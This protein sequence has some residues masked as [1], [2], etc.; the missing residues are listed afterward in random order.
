MTTIYIHGVPD[1]LYGEIK[2]LA[3]E[4]RQSLNAEVLSIIENGLRER[5]LLK[6]RREALAGLRALRERIGNTGN[7]S[8]ALLREDRAR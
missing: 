8:L 7:D 3:A 1:E 6:Q 5:R 2:E 4:D